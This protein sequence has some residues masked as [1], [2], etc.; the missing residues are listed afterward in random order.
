MNLIAA[1]SMAAM[2]AQPPPDGGQPPSTSP[3]F[4]K[5]TFSKLFSSVSAPF[6]NLQVKATSMTHRG[7]PAIS[8]STAAMES[9]AT[10]F[11]FSLVEK[12]SKQRSAMEAVRKLFTSLDLH[13]SF[14]IGL[15]DARHVLIRLHNEADFLWV[16]TRSI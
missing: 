5:K 1:T 11:R 14:S 10:P 12:F 4:R 3:G 8:F 9:I 6:P 2:V 15:L 13:D 16:W 7:E